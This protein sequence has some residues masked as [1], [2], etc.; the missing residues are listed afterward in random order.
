MSE[1]SKSHH[2][3]CS[4]SSCGPNVTRREF[5][6]LAGAAAAAAWM[7]AGPAVAGPFE[8]KDFGLVSRIPG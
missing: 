1:T 4:S 6:E 8:A 7:S 3:G 2:C 5:L